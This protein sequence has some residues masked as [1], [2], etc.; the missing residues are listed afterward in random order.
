MSA[1]TQTAPGIWRWDGTDADHGFPIVGH[2]VSDEQGL[3]LVDPPLTSG[4]AAE[5]RALGRPAAIVITGKWHVR[6]GPKWAKELAIPVYAPASARDELAEAGGKADRELGDGDRVGAWQALMLRAER[7]GA[8]Y[9]EI[10]LWNE[11][12]GILITGDL[13]TAEEEGKVELGPHA[14]SGI[15]MEALRPLVER[16]RALRPRLLLSSHIGHRED[17]EAILDGALRG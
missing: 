16:L 10:A 3:L 2:I 12:K 1:L 17:A 8:T 9:E 6:G 13:I 14:F 7:P 4:D 15:P 5:I 11:G